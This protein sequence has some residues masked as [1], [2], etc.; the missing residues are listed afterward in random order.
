M[1][2]REL[3]ARPN[4]DPKAV[5]QHVEDAVLAGDP[6]ALEQLIR[7]HWAILQENPGGTWIGDLRHDALG[8]R[9]D[10]DSLPD[11]RAIIAAKQDF[12][13]WDQFAVFRE[14]LRDP[15]SPVAQFEAAVD[16][17]VAGDAVTLDRLLRQNPDLIRARSARK[18]RSTL[19]HYVGANGFEGYR[20]RTPKNAV[21]IARILLDAGADIDA[22]ADMYRGTTTLGLVATSVYPV[23]AGVQAAL[24]DLL[25]DRGASLDR[26]VAPTYTDGRVVNAC[27]ANGRGEGAELVAARGAS[28]DLEGA[29]GVGRLDVVKTFFNDDGTL[30]SGATPYQMKSG[31]KWACAYG[32]L[33]VVRFLLERGIDVTERHRGE[34]SLHVA[35]FG[36]HVETVSLLIQRGAPVG[37]EDETWAATPLGWAVYAWSM[38]PPGASPDRYHE[39]VGLL[40]GAGAPVRPEWLDDDAITRDPSMLAALE[41]RRPR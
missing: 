10:S 1:P 26:A 33:D 39:V 18:H 38:L 7:E 17:V 24:I 9:R 32:R 15:Q 29:A 16:A 27:L 36:G 21:Q 25:V 13:S 14:S 2:A 34:T 31:F 40:V 37:A 11:A 5:W 6:G 28:L 12:E 41:G 30:K 4:L 19:L 35:A 23:Q 3:P 22:V 20:Q 8:N